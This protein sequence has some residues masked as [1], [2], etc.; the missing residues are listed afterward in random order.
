MSSRK[1]R[2]GGDDDDGTRKRV[3]A[4]NDSPSLLQTELMHTRSSII[5]GLKHPYTVALC[6]NLAYVAETKAH[7][8]RVYDMA[9]GSPVPTRVYALK[10][11]PCGI[12]IGHTYLYVSDSFT[13]HT[14]TAIHK[15]SG[16]VVWT[17]DGFNHPVQLSLAKGMPNQEEMLWVADA[18]AHRLVLLS[19]SDGTERR[20]IAKG[21][22]LS[23]KRPHGV[24]ATPD[25]GLIV[26]DTYQHRIVRLDDQGRVLVAKGSRGGA[27]GQFQ[28]PREVAMAASGRHVIVCDFSNSRLQVLDAETL[29]PLGAYGSKGC[30]RS[31]LNFPRGLALD[32]SRV[33]VADSGN[34]R[35]VELD[36]LLT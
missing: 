3:G 6:D 17:A 2:K 10:T 33:L 35:V 26:A 21:G 32:G 4:I 22:A 14:V 31:Q 12:A 16:E 8:V 20:A 25:G 36:L 1:K 7:C 27:L 5:A 9:S 15:E 29:A 24:T 19:A 23:L 34:G 30:E 18:Y 28:Y 11:E 13:M